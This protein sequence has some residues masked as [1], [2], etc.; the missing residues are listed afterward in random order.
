MVSSLS[1]HVVV[2]AAELKTRY[3]THANYVHQVGDAELTAS[4]GGYL[5]T[6]DA[7]QTVRAA[8]ASDV[9]R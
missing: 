3:G 6:S 7:V 1:L 8:I 5:L 9:A 2:T 4:R